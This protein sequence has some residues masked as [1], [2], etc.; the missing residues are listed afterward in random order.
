MVAS[1]FLFI[2]HGV[3][4]RKQLFSRLVVL[5]LVGFSG[6]A[7]ASGFQLFEANGAG[8]GNFYAGGA[9]IA[10]DASTAYFNPAGLVRMHHPQIV[11]SAVNIF[12]DVS[13]KGTD[14]WSN[15]TG[16]AAI[17]ALTGVTLP[18]TYTQ[19]GS[20]QG[21][22]YHLVPSFEYASP[23]NENFYFGFSVA[24]PFGLSTDYGTS[25]FVRYS[26]T[27]TSLQ[28]IDFSPS[29]GFKITDKLSAGFGVDADY[30]DATL[31]AMAGLPTW[32]AY[33]G[34]PVSTYDTKSENDADGW[35]YGYHAGLLY[36]FDPCNRLGLSYFSK[37]SYTV[38]GTSHFKGNLAGG[39]ATLTTPTSSE[40]VNNNLTADT[41]LPA[42]TMLSY[43]HQFNPA[44]S[45]MATVAYT[46]W[47]VFNNLTLN[48][49]AGATATLAYT[50]VTVTLSQNYRNT[51]RF[52]TGVNY[53]PVKDW[54]FRA[55]V[56]YDQTPTQDQDRN[57]RL[58]DGNRTA[59]ALGAHYQMVKNVGVDV[60]WTHLFI[61]DGEV[62]S[63]QV[64][65]IQQTTTSAKAQ[66]HADLVGMQLTW[67]L[68]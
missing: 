55:G 23:I 60:G 16:T 6:S 20:A 47:G 67:D 13:L 62:H 31:D 44:W 30:L 38:N 3:I 54:V 46:E 4:M 57:A 2:E 21:G 1:F 24:A 41:T 36:Q 42:T 26:A 63:P 29:I 68:A 53:Q 11:L 49:V 10:D 19:S 35:G 65:G 33:R 32:A 45:A 5:G 51:W 39:S 64:L 52:A 66:S 9:A 59:I 22:G 58:P 18:N 15:P 27:N 8:T 56:G 40:F 14:T 48:N 28:V 34:L 25:S 7:F 61:Q 17:R 37:V 12:T 50:P 43:F